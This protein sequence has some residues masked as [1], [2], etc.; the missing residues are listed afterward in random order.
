MSSIVIKVTPAGGG[1]ARTLTWK[2]VKIKK[3]LDEICHSLELELPKAEQK[4]VHKHD[5]IIVWYNSPLL[6]QRRRIT[7][8]LLDEV[9]GNVEGGSQTVL[10]TGRSVARDIIDSQWS[11]T[12]KESPD[13]L[14]VTKT[15]AKPFEIEVI[16]MPT[17]QNGTKPVHSFSWESES[18]WVKLLAEADN[19]GYLITS[20]QKGN[21]YVWK[22]A[23]GIRG[24]GFAVK[25]GVNTIRIS[26]T[27]IGAEQFHTYVVKGGGLEGTVT[28]STC[29]NNRILTIALSDE[30]VSQET[31]ERRARTEMLRRRESNIVV[32]VPGW[33]LSDAQIKKLGSTDYKE[34][35]WEVNF[36]IPVS[37][38]SLGIDDN[39]LITQVEYTADASTM[40]CDLT[41]SNKE[42]Y[43]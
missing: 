13:L 2:R 5:K 30:S 19:Q 21:L 18:P 25:E 3:S 33:G 39:L 8:V 26:S 37:T 31:V 17:N 14:T 16:H 24:E 28:D 42:V 40:R 38:P 9:G 20:N 4:N 27:E 23:T 6:P 35:F 1:S 41:L 7:T 32:T 29:P 11:G 10:C 43:Q 34:I 22:A 15:V 36:L 12:I